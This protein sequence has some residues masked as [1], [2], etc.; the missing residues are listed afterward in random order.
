[1]SKLAMPDPFFV[2]L[3][4]ASRKR[5]L[6]MSAAY[7]G[8]LPWSQK[9]PNLEVEFI[10]RLGG[11][12]QAHRQLFPAVTARDDVPHKG[13]PSK[14]S[15]GCRPPGPIREPTCYVFHCLFGTVGA[16]QET[17]LL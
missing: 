8:R 3:L 16:V 11:L 4:C 7:R 15:G 14:V 6:G 5:L 1:M 13:S 12:G 2:G 9:H 17:Q 10:P